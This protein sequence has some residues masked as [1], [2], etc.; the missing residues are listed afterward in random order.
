MDNTTVF[1][2]VV[3]GSSPDRDAKKDAQIIASFFY[4]IKKILL[5]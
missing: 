3:S 5:F 2:T 1:G 4:L